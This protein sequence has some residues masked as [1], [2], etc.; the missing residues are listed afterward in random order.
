[1]TTNSQIQ[2]ALNGILSAAS[3][4]YPISWP[5]INFAPPESSYWLEVMHLPNRGVDDQLANDGHVSPQGIYQVM[6]V[7]RP[8]S[9]IALRQAAESVQ[10]AF[11][12][13]TNV[14]DAVRV[15]RHPYTTNVQYE[16]DRMELAVTIEYSE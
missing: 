6:V 11:P 7:G 2:S 10:A 9:E 12:K 16:S 4:G 3:L 15:T 13:G 14:V 8:G 1:M 5:G